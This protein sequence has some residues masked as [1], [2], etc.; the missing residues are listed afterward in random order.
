LN[1]RRPGERQATFDALVDALHQ[2]GSDVFHQWLTGEAIGTEFG[3]SAADIAVVQQYLEAEGFRINHV[4]K[5]GM[6]IDFSG[7]ASQVEESFRTEIHNLV[8]PDGR[9][10]YSA[11]TPASLPE[12][13]VPV[14]LGFTAINNIES[15]P[16]FQPAGR[17]TTQRAPQPKDAVPCSSGICNDIG[18]QDFYTIYNERPIINNGTING[19]G[20]T[21]ALLEPTDINPADVAAFRTMF[22]VLPN[23]PPLKMLNGS[24][25]IACA[26]PGINPSYEEEAV[27]DTEWAGAVAPGASLLVMSCPNVY[28]SA[29]AVVEDNLASVLSLSFIDSELNGMA[30]VY[31]TLW[32]QA[33]AQGQT[34][35]VCAGDSGSANNIVGMHAAIAATGV[36]VN[37]YASSA[38]NV[39]AGGTDFQDVYNAAENDTAFGPSHYWSGTNHSGASSALAYVPE[40]VWNSS[41]A[42]SLIANEA[43]LTP[44][45]FCDANPTFGNMGGGG[46]ASVVNPRPSWQS[47]SVYG[48]PDTAG[49]FNFRLLPDLSFFAAPGFWMHSLVLYESDLSPSLRYGGGTSFVAP[50]MA[51][52]FALISQK[53]GT[54]LGQPDYVL[55]S[56]AGAAYGTSTFSGGSCNGSG[57]ASNTGTTSSTPSSTCVF[58]DIVTG[59]NSQECTA[60]ANN[61]FSDNGSVGILTTSTGGPAYPA[62]PGYDLATGIGSANINN[63]VNTWPSPSFKLSEDPGGLTLAAGQSG[64]TV[65]AVIPVNGFSSIVGFSCNG[66]PAYATCSFSPIAVR[67]GGVPATTA[68]T[69]ATAAPATLA[70]RNH[71]RPSGPV[72]ALVLPGILVVFRRRALRSRLRLG[73]S[74]LA[75]VV[76]F[77]PAVLLSGCDHTPLLPLNSGT[78]A[79]TYKVT[80][81]GST[82]GNPGLTQSLALTITVKN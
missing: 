74:V 35:I 82:S 69:I 49:V 73:A 30:P 33:V 5:S 8:L 63:L 62:G 20:V 50:Q 29:E 3:P 64:T 39:A 78:P 4:A 71:P 22:N 32:E 51:G 43:G 17:E 65:I 12:A 75:T 81:V 57:S 7:T 46:G 40:T 15:Q 45:G 18:P 58:Y 38:Y 26:D 72:L 10:R 9:R 24:T 16:A 27:L 44:N 31:S 41:C 67:P 37:A 6:F 42:G 52:I 14:V 13:L 70:T 76:V 47:G 66:L 80:V 55:Y 19:S 28:L 34:V 56:L 48:L 36:A 21:I 59:D 60:G 2:P 25:S 1:L 61:C 77:A 23:M 53:T 79:G 54:V 11:I 68:L